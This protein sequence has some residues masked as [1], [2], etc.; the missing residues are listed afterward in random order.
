MGTGRYRN[1]HVTPQR[2]NVNG[3]A[4]THAFIFEIR[5]VRWD[6]NSCDATAEVRKKLLKYHSYWER[7]IATSYITG[8]C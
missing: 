2:I 7:N 5:N 1:S 8:P 3:S 4:A 6:P